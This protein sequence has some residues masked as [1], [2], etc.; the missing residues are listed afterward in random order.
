[1]AFTEQIDVI[2]ELNNIEQKWQ[3]KTCIGEWKLKSISGG[4]GWMN[5][6]AA[7]E[8]IMN[9]VDIVSSAICRFGF[10]LHYIILFHE[11]KPFNIINDPIV[12]PFKYWFITHTRTQPSP[13]IDLLIEMCNCCQR[14]QQQCVLHLTWNWGIVFIFALGKF[15][16]GFIQFLCTWLFGIELECR[17]LHSAHT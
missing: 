1:M 15:V 14:N 12:F 6:A 2:L 3:N 4:H 8:I 7:I 10:L 16:L 9:F 13:H 11:P 5:F 17:L